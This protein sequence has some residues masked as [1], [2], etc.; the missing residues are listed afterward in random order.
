MYK[1]YKIKEIKI[2]IKT[3]GLCNMNSSIQHNISLKV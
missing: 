1:M 3:F 2:K